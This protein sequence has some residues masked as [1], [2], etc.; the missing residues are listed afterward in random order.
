VSEL[1]LLR[2]AAQRLV[3]PP[4]GTPAEAVRWLTCVQAQDLPGALLSVAL[5]SPGGRTAVT[6]ALDAGEVV[7]SWPMRGTLHLTAA[8]DLPWP[9]D[10]LGV[11]VLAGAAT[12]RAALEITAADVERARELAVAS[13]HGGRRLRRAGLLAAIAAGGVSTAGQRGYHLLWYLAQ[14]GT[15]VLGPTE[16]GDQQFVL[17]DEWVPTPRRLDREEALG[18]LALRF[19]RSHGPATVKDL[20]AGR[21]S[22]SATS[23]PGSQ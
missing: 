20:V 17:L 16:D 19:F 7:R 6:A 9:L 14:T 15:L 5:R 3:G 12:R 18:E 4:A 2:M 23:G 11:R 13:L 8:E 1:S 22:A 10:L 21:A